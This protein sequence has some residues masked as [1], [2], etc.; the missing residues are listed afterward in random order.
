MVNLMRRQLSALGLGIALLAVP[1]VSAH[2]SF[3]AEFDAQ[4]P[5]TLRG[6]ITKVERTNPHGWIFLDVKS[7]DGKVVNWAVETGGP[8]ALARRGVT[9]DS[10]PVGT[11]VIVTG[12]RA[13]NG[14]PTINGEDIRLPDGRRL[15]VGS[16]G[17]DTPYANRARDDDKTGK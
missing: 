9:K 17:G 16:S 3:S 6:T 10:L 14:S 4:L 11:E 1:S 7:P 12:F 2:H 13:K 5:A 15:F 8:L